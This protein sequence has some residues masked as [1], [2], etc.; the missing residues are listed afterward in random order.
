VQR[1][2]LRNRQPGDGTPSKEV[3]LTI[4]NTLTELLLGFLTLNVCALPLPEEGI[5]AEGDRSSEQLET[6]L[7]F[8]VS[9]YVEINLQ[10]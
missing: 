4:R 5:K 1:I 6:E 2:T 10:L 8:L 9:F 7:L 3:G